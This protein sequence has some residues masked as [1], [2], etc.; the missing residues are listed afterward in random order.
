LNLL[1]IIDA[2]VGVTE[3]AGGGAVPA[4]FLSKTE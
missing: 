1:E 3:V 2:F 4:K